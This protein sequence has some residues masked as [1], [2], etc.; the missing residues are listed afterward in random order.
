MVDDPTR[1]HSRRLTRNHALA[2]PALECA[3]HSV[4]PNEFTQARECSSVAQYIKCIVV[5]TDLKGA[6]IDV[7]EMSRI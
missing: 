4:L 7:I 5:V 2:P 3:G 6:D 1:K